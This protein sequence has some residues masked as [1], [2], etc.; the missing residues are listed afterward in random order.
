MLNLVPDECYKV[1]NIICGGIIPGPGHPKNID[2]FLFP[3]LAH[4]SV[5]QK[6]GFKIWDGYDCTVALTLVFVLLV[7]TDAVTI[8]DVSGL[9]GVRTLF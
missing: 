1:H 4:V 2:P 6:E 5:I 9:A 8:A 3:G 7:L